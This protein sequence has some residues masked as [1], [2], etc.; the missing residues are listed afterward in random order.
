VTT[1]D[2]LAAAANVA[3]WPR[4]HV[5]VA[6]LRRAEGWLAAIDRETGAHAVLPGF[7][8]GAAPLESQLNV[9]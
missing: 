8:P 1:S 5:A 9:R 3:Y 2:Y 4:V 6:L 7:A